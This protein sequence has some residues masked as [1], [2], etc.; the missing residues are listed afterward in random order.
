[1]NCYK[2]N[3]QTNKKAKNLGKKVVQNFGF[4]KSFQFDIASFNSSTIL[5]SH[6]GLFVCFFVG[7][8]VD[9]ELRSGMLLTVW[10]PIGGSEK[11]HHNFDPPRRGWLLHFRF[12]EML[13]TWRW[14]WLT[15]I[16]HH[17]TLGLVIDKL[18]SMTLPRLTRFNVAWV[19]VFLLRKI[20]DSFL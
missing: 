2:T 14:N 7:F 13:S 11:Y 19:A 4:R 17:H 6:R 16:I 20:I 18:S 8:K 1:M 12:L 9:L 5:I 15:R 3:K 10:S